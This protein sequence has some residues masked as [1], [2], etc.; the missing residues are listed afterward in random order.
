MVDSTRVKAQYD[1]VF[2]HTA[3]GLRGTVRTPVS[4]IDH[5][6]I[7]KMSIA[8]LEKSKALEQV[9]K[10]VAAVQLTAKVGARSES[11]KHD[12]RV[13]HKA[14]GIYSGAII[15]NGTKSHSQMVDKSSSSIAV[16]I[17]DLS[18]HRSY[19]GIFN[20]HNGGGNRW[21]HTGQ[22]LRRKFASHGSAWQHDNQNRY[23]EGKAR[24]GDL[25][26]MHDGIDSYGPPRLLHNC[27]ARR[28]ENTPTDGISLIVRRGYRRLAV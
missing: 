3:R 24:Y 15:Y 25:A 17:N 16:N 6:D 9:S 4:A 5:N 26:N 7:D 19:G 27:A 11:R 22:L 23:L 2:W 12:G 10:Q 20:A 18:C 28:L 13:L 14:T 21:S 8:L 1:S